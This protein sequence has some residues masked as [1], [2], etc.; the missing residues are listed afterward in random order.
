MNKEQ[1]IGIVITNMLKQIKLKEDIL[2]HK[3]EP[4]NLEDY[5]IKEIP[6]T[7][8]RQALEFILMAYYRQKN[9]FVFSLT[10]SDL[11]SMTGIKED[12]IDSVLNST[13]IIDKT[14]ESY[15]NG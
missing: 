7:N 9:E 6:L 8:L 4:S 12:I 14:Y 11:S 15:Y 10:L 1:V 5:S 3:K 2:E 13:D